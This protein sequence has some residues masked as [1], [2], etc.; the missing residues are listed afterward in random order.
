MATVRIEVELDASGAITGVR[1]LDDALDK[2]SNRGGIGFGKLTASFFSAEVALQAVTKA[3]DLARAA[4]VGTFSAGFDAV[5]TFEKSSLSLQATLA[6]QLQ[7][8]KDAGENFAAVGPIARAVTDRLIQLDAQSATTF[9]NLQLGFQTFVASGGLGTVRT[10]EEAL[11]AT[12]LLVNASEILSNS[13]NKQL[14]VQVAIRSVLQGQSFVQSE[15]AQNL[16]SSGAELKEQAASYREHR[17]LLDRLRE[18]LSGIDEASKQFS[19]TWEGVLSTSETL[20]DL[21]L[22]EAFTQFF[23]T[24]KDGAAELLAEVQDNRREI[25]AYVAVA[26]AGLKGVAQIVVT[27]AGS[28]GSLLRSQLGEAGLGFVEDKAYELITALKVLE[29]AANFEVTSPFELAGAYRAAV[30]ETAVLRASITRES[31][32][33][34]DQIESDLNSLLDIDLSGVLKPLNQGSDEADKNLEKLLKKVERLGLTR[35][36]SYTAALRLE[37]QLFGAASRRLSKELDFTK[38]IRSERER[39]AEL[40]GALGGPLRTQEGQPGPVV[41]QDPESLDSFLVGAQ[42]LTPVIPGGEAVSG[43]GIFADDL[44]SQLGNLTDNFG[45]YQAAMESAGDAFYA[46]VTGHESLGK[47]LQRSFQRLLAQ[48]A[49]DSAVKAIKHTALGIAALTPWGAPLYGPAAAQ[50][51]AAALFAATAAAAGGAAKALGG[52][53]ASAGA[54][55]GVGFGAPQQRPDTFDVTTLRSVP[56]TRQ[57]QLIGQLSATLGRLDSAPAGHVVTMGVQERGAVAVLGSG[58]VTDLTQQAFSE[59][60]I[61]AG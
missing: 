54:G 34:A 14:A 53:G 17:D 44:T 56:D 20:R 24:L 26:A 61:G 49:A 30:A 51:K 19:G 3:A 29:R 50:F 58:G 55:G 42:D 41:R 4:L 10:L 25:S 28:G 5:R 35:H 33:A 16:A 8:S 59:P 31:K 18:K 9:D 12:N 1:N 46:F 36:G 52:G 11:Q 60:A 15:V 2:T 39:I 57:T 22:R 38:Q 47:A 48:E 40:Q 7:L 45:L 27:L 21:F 37:D 23:D 32:A 43:F 13:A 6:S